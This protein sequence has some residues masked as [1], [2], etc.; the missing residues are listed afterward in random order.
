MPGFISKKIEEK[1]EKGPKGV[2]DAGG[3]KKMYEENGGISNFEK[4][5]TH[6]RVIV[7]GIA[8]GVIFGFI[9]GIVG[10]IFFFSGLLSSIKIGPEELF[11]AQ[12][13]KI[14]RN[15]QVNVLEDKKI[16][17][18]SESVKS[19]VVAVFKKKVGSDKILDNV[20]LPGEKLGSGLVITNDG[21]VVTQKEA[22]AGDEALVVVTAD[23]QILVVEK[24]VTDDYSGLIF[25]KTAGKNLNTVPMAAAAQS[26]GG[27]KAVIMKSLGSSTEVRVARI[28]DDNFSDNSS[29][30]ALIKATSQATN[31]MLLDQKIGSGFNGGPVFDL[32]GQVIGILSVND[33]AEK[34]V[35]YDDFKKG[36]EAVLSGA[37][38]IEPISLGLRYL[39][40]DQLVGGSIKIKKG[41]E[42]RPLEKGALV[43]EVVAGL[44]AAKAKILV[45]DVITKVG[46][47]EITAENGLGRLIQKYKKGDS[48]NLTI[49]RQGSEE[50]KVVT[51]NF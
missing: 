10:V 25:L 35:T 49:L 14:E 16:S 17:Q 21:W 47:D 37:S 22:A 42:V 11:P 33:G 5:V 9:S 44:A 43:I 32:G 28:M 13:I 41:N 29:A 51:V 30:K 50:E 34:I 46:N 8:T 2:A 18:M 36:M 24:K 4:P 7:V 26:A 38:T 45:N 20:Y 19:A 39:N 27:D 12:Q 40:L 48:V 1:K 6:S 3:V 31:F 15:E 23:K